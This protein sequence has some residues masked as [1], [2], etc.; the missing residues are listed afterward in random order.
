MELEAVDGP[1]QLLQPKVE[2]KVH[3]NVGGIIF[4]N[5]RS[6]R[7]HVSQCGDYLVFPRTSVIRRSD[8]KCLRPTVDA[9]KFRY[10]R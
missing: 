9:E 5:A 7:K 10:P 4:L 3:L 8:P 2:S 6:V 1:Q